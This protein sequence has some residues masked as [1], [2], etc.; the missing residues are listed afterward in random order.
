V[1]IL[2]SWKEMNTCTENENCAS[3][4]ITHGHKKCNI[5]TGVFFAS[6]MIA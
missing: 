2:A 5:T 4:T 6:R 3:K 1:P